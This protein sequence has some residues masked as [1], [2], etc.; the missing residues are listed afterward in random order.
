MPNKIS[1]YRAAEPIAPLKGS[2]AN[3]QVVDRSQGGGNAAPA[4]STGTADQLTLTG[5]AVTMQKLSAA[6]AAAPTVNASKVASIKQ[7]V[8]NGSYQVNSTQVA[9][10]MLQ[11]ERGLK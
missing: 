4:A 11:F 1:G 7:A 6:V 5:S 2:G 10:K 9:N 8:Q 3:G